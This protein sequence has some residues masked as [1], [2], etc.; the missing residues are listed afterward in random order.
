MGTLYVFNVLELLETP[1][2][3]ERNHEAIMCAS[4]AHNCLRRVTR[5]RQRKLR[6]FAIYQL[7]RADAGDV[8]T[9]H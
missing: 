3:V 6:S 1:T 2:I 5:G 8:T 7:F 4:S 9:H